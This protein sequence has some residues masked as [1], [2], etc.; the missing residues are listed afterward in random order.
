MLRPGFIIA[1]LC[2]S[3]LI[4]T[5]QV[6]EVRVMQRIDTAH[7]QVRT[8]LRQWVDSLSTWSEPEPW[9]GVHV[10]RPTTQ[11]IVRDWF[12]HERARPTV[13]SI[14]FDGYGYS[15]RTLFLIDRGGKAG[16]MPLGILRCRFLPGDQPQPWIVEDPLNASTHLWDTTRIASLRFIHTQVYIVDTSEVEQNVATMREA[17]DRFALDVPDSVMCYVVSSRD[18]L[19]LLLGI[20][21]YAFPPSGMSYPQGGIILRSYDASL[22]HELIHVLFAGFAHTHPVFR[23]GIATLIGGTGALDA[24]EAIAEFVREENERTTPSFVQLFTSSDVEQP[25][26]YI[27]GAMLCRAILRMAGR[28]VLFELMRMDRTSD[29]MYRVATLLDFDIADQQ[30]SMYQFI[31]EQSQSAAERK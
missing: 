7:P 27:A 18:E 21:Y 6:D 12:Y 16:E 23:E 31:V 3:A 29:I 30:R 10:E 2:A 5:A 11:S 24:S 13:L 28:G 14:E 8:V 17:A 25:A 19:C 1:F 26:M 22:T 20:E 9:N 4:A 15:V